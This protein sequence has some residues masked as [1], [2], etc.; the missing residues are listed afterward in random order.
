M[1]EER[2]K[3]DLN[4][5]KRV[6]DLT[7]PV[8]TRIWIR[9]SDWVKIACEVAAVRPAGAPLPTPQNFKS[10]TLGRLTAIHAGTD[11]QEVCDLLNVDE[12]RKSN[13]RAKHDAF[14][15]PA[16]TKKDPIEYTDAESTWEMPEE[17]RVQTEENLR[18]VYD[19]PFLEV[20]K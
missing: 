7:Y 5:L 9:T 1:A 2:C 18:R 6:R 11:D 15:M 16:G 12:E 8:H 3:R 4:F 20:V 19:D 17:L 13:F 10:L 14:A